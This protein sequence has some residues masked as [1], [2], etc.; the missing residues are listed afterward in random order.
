MWTAGH[1]RADRSPFRFEVTASPRHRSDTSISHRPEKKKNLKN[2]HQQTQL[3]A[4]H[5][6]G[7]WFFTWW[8]RRSFIRRSRRY[9]RQVRPRLLRS[10]RG[11]LRMWSGGDH[12]VT[13]ILDGVGNKATGFV[14]S[15]VTTPSEEVPKENSQWCSSAHVRNEP[16]SRPLP[17]V[18]GVAVAL[19]LLPLLLLLMLRALRF[20]HPPRKPERVC[21]VFRA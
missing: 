4:K 12:A 5:S 16:N 3:L 15:P 17:V 7:G 1:C 20:V 21:L 19:A 8:C 13:R 9:P 14:R 6:S 2:R 11:E 18:S 10:G